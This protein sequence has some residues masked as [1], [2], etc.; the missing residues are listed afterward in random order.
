MFSRAYRFAVQML[1][2]RDEFCLFEVCTRL[3]EEQTAGREEIAAFYFF[4]PDEYWSGQPTRREDEAALRACAERLVSLWPKVAFHFV[5]LAIGPLRVAGRPRLEL[6]RLARNE[7]LARARRDGW[8]HV[9]LLDSDEIWRRG[10][11]AQLGQ[12]LRRFRLRRLSGV[13]TTATPIIGV[14]GYPVDGAHDLAYIYVRSDTTFE[15]GRIPVPRRDHLPGD[16]LWHFVATRP[17]ID[18]LKEKLRHSGHYDDP[19]YRFDAWIER[20]LPGLRPGQE[21]VHFFQGGER[22]PRVREWTR[23]ELAEIPSSLHVALGTDLTGA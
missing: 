11:L 22:W 18:E 10:T 17:N 14:P 1:V 13:W 7:A 3:L 16:R 4:C 8:R 9:L 12:L 5:R 23:A 2:I 21:N 6:E 15:T 19:I 20:Q